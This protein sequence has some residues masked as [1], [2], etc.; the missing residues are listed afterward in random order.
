MFDNEISQ[1]IQLLKDK[2]LVW[3]QDFEGIRLNL[4]GLLEKALQNEYHYLEPE[5]GEIALSL[6]KEKGNDVRGN[7]AKREFAFVQSK[8]TLFE[9]RQIGCGDSHSCSCKSSV[10]S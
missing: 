7:D 1:A 2:N 6:I 4:S 8:N 10:D 3:S 5:I 9:L